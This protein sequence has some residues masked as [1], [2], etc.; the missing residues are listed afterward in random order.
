LLPVAIAFVLLAACGGREPEAAETETALTIGSESVYRVEK[1]H[2]ASGPVVSGSLEA[3]RQATVRA[4][5]AGPVVETSV[6]EGQSVAAGAVLGRIDDSGL[7]ESV[8]SAESAVRSA[9][10]QLTVARRNAERAEA[11]VAGG[12]LPEREAENARWNVTN[13]QAM[14]DDARS[15]QTLAREQ[16]AKTVVRAPFA[17]VVSDRAVA[18]GDTVQPGSELFT[19]VDP[20]RMRLAAQVPAERLGELQVGTAVEFTIAGY[21]GRFRGEVERINPVADPTTRQ[22]EI[23]V[24]LPND[25]GRLVAGL[26]AQGRV[27]AVARDALA[28]PVAAIDHGAEGPGVL[29]VAGGRVERVPVELGITDE[30]SER[31]EVLGGLAAGDVLLVG[32]ARGITPGSR[33]TLQEAASAARGVRPAS[34]GEAPA[35]EG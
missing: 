33:V 32:A 25:T 27:A 18:L 21:P 12:A 22:V 5:V 28:V 31:V 34:G 7:R 24:S 1:A 20:R 2:L 10:Q 3:E 29:R 30:E 6:E 13:A 8:L 17:G 23:H 26:F 19:L 15:R 4:E 16:L 9:D 11:L 14:L 35:A